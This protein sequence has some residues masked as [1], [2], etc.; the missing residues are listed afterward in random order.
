MM[1]ITTLRYVVTSK[2][3]I[4]YYNYRHL[5]NYTSNRVLCGETYQI[6]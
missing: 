4:L 3:L 5:S 6:V 2:F 1:N